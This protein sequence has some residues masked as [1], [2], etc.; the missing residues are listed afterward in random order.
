MTLPHMYTY[1]QCDPTNLGNKLTCPGDS[2]HM[3]CVQPLVARQEIYV[4]DLSS[5]NML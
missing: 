3:I 2:L 1:Y 4:Q 5:L